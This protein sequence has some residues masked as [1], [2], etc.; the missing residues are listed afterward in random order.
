[1]YTLVYKDN[2]TDKVIGSMIISNYTS[3][4]DLTAFDII[5]KN[6]AKYIVEQE[7]EAN[8]LEELKRFKYFSNAVVDFDK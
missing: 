8:I 3:E 2:K 4:E 6:A 5:V 7:K 1:M